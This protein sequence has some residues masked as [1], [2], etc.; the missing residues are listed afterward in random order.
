M[1]REE[2]APR[3]SGVRRIRGDRSRGR[4]NRWGDQG[5]WHGFGYWSTE[6]SIGSRSDSK[7]ERELCNMEESSE[8][9]RVL[10]KI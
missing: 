4:T 7:K 9:M 8:R 10:L 6:A 3:R 2:S 1:D 5:K